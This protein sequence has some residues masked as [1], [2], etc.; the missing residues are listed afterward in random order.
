MHL[1][2]KGSTFNVNSEPYLSERSEL[3][4]TGKLVTLFLHWETSLSVLVSVRV[5]YENP[6][7][8]DTNHLVVTQLIGASNRL[9]SAFFFLKSEFISHGAYNGVQRRS[10]T[11]YYYLL[12][13]LLRH[14]RS[15]ERAAC[16][17]PMWQ[18]G[19]VGGWS[20]CVNKWLRGQF[21]SRNKGP[22]H[23]PGS[24]SARG[25]LQALVSS[26]KRSSI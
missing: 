25:L 4:V 11:N 15:K 24:H 13:I 7:D 8:S 20:C 19:F 18:K 26:R 16:A 17:G 1:S 10:R 23:Y 22:V 6:Q 21:R 12:R 2:V 9:E 3:R 14:V 5:W